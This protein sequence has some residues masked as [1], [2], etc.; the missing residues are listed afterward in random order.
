MLSVKFIIDAAIDIDI[1]QIDSL[2][3]GKSHSIDSGVSGVNTKYIDT[4][5]NKVKLY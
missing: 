2:A 1:Y 4:N 3:F 5:T